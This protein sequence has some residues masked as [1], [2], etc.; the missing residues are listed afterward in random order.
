MKIKSTLW[1][2]AIAL[3][4]S[5]A[6]KVSEKLVSSKSK[7]TFFS[8]TSVED[9][10]A[11]NFKSV[12]TLDPNTGDFVASVPMQSFDFDKWLMER[13]FNQ[14]KFLHTK[15]YPKAK[16]IGKLSNL[17]GVNFNQ[18]GTYQAEISGEMTIRGKTNKLKAPVEITVSSDQKVTLN[19][20]FNI[21]LS[22]YGIAFEEGKPS[23]N[24]AKV[25]EVK[26]EYIY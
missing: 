6:F 19:T 16:M 7:I 24:I 9:I 4:L 18:A 13:H 12:S 8:H 2:L 10:E 5:F 23:T 20:Q 26:A 25:I 3:P 15:E 21:K 14:E 1:I 11:E 22:D 17:A